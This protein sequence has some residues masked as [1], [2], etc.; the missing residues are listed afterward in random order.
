MTQDSPAK[1][2][3]KVVAHV[4]SS[5][6]EIIPGFLENR[7]K[8]TYTIITS[9]EQLNYETIRFLGHDMRGVGS[10]Y[11]FDVITDIGKSLEMAAKTKNSVKIRK[12][13]Q[14]LAAYLECVEIVYE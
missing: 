13:V 4:D 5:L 10:G 1:I 7:W 14:E 3:A 2:G 9:V 8:D 6:K 11:G 12:L